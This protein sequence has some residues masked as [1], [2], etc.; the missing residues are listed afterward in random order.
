MSQ[1]ETP[2]SKSARDLLTRAG[3]H[4]TRVQSGEVRVRRGYM[5]LAEK[6]T[7]DLLVEVLPPV[8]GWLEVK[9]PDG[10]TREAQKIWHAKAKLRGCLVATF[11]EPKEA[12]AIVQG[13]RSRIESE[14]DVRAEMR[15]T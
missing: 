14:R 1:L 9:R 5:H 8:M 11:D 2:I 3:F 6:G 13:W 4:V 10:P 15:R 7:P 12:L